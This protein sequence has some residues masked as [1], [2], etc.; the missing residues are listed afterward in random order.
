MNIFGG[1]STSLQDMVCIRRGRIVGC[2]VSH[3]SSKD[4]GVQEGFGM[5]RSCA[6]ASCVSILQGEYI[7]GTYFAEMRE[8]SQSLEKRG[9]LSLT[10]FACAELKIRP[11]DVLPRVSTLGTLSPTVD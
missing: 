1:C 3:D 8:T 2:Y 11:L 5:V 4:L 6:V 10:N 7:R 9:Y